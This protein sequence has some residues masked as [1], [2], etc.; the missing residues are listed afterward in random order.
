MLGCWPPGLCQL[1]SF[2]PDFIRRMRWVSQMPGGMDSETCGLSDSKFDLCERSHRCE[3]CSHR[4][5]WTLIG[6]GWSADQFWR[7]RCPVRAVCSQRPMNPAVRGKK[8]CMEVSVGWL[9][10]SCQCSFIGFPIATRSRSHHLGQQ[11]ILLAVVLRVGVR[12]GP[13]LHYPTLVSKRFHV[14]QS[15]LASQVYHDGL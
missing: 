14:A 9:R 13:L 2:R 11:K 12:P 7:A 4:M 8:V 3:L 1:N 6:D 5:G 15:K 10:W